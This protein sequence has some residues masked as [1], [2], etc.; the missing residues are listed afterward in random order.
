MDQAGQN[1]IFILGCQGGNA[2]K[3]PLKEKESNMKIAIVGLGVAGS[4]LL[5]VLSKDHDVVG[6]EMQ[7]EGQFDAVCAWGSSK[8]E[9]SSIF[10]RIGVEFSGYVLFDGGTL[11]IE[12]SQKTLE[13]PLKGLAAYD[14]HQLE[15]DLT[16]G[17]NANYGVRVSRETFPYSK[18]DLVIDA[19]SLQRAL[20]PRIKEQMLVPCVEYMIDYHEHGMTPYND[21]FVKPFPRNSGY[22]WYFPLGDHVAYVGAGDYFRKHNDVL[23]AFNSEHGGTI[24]KKIGRPV[25]LSSPFLCQPFSQGN[26]VGVGESIGTVFPILGEGIIPSLHCAELLVENLEAIPQYE[27]SVL[28]KFKVFHDVY[29]LIKLKINDELSTLRHARLMWNTYQTMRTQEDR[30]GMQ[31]KLNDLRAI[32][33]G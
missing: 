20:L 9:L 15:L 28:K 2:L 29:R 12:L 3:G 16:K 33:K 4:Y 24:K 1:R 7:Q 21:F 32:I 8:V 19:T 6:Y 31:V 18:Y 11:Q 26:V 5:N 27:V 22:F 30:F 17:K 25:R 13:I 23:D 10:S 14:K